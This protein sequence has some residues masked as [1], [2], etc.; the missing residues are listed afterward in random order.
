VTYE[1][2]LNQKNGRLP[3]N[4]EVGYCLPRSYTEQF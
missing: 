1:V 4:I 3:T 2:V